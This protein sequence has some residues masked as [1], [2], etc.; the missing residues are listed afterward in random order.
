M[1]ILTFIPTFPARSRIEKYELD[2]VFSEEPGVCKSIVL[3]AE[4]EEKPRGV[5]S[6]SL[7]TCSVYILKAYGTAT[8]LLVGPFEK[9]NEGLISEK[10]PDKDVVYRK[11]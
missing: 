2:T 10:E 3:E 11:R 9:E 1:G 5:G 6:P 8:I 4:K 7:A